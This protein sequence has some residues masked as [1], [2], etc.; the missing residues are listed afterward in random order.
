MNAPKENRSDPERIRHGGCARRPST[1]SRATEIRESGGNQHG[2]T[3]R[4][5]RLPSGFKSRPIPNA[6]FR[7]GSQPVPPSS[8]S[9]L[10]APLEAARAKPMLPVTPRPSCHLSPAIYLCRR[11]PR[12]IRFHHSR[13]G[14][15]PSGSERIVQFEP[16]PIGNDYTGHAPIG[17][18]HQYSTR[19]TR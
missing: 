18:R 16:Y 10:R 2:R 9:E 8:V 1:G 12:G 14:S 7:H 17:R 19:T 11:V 15:R 5:K 6:Y 3:D 4:G 13:I